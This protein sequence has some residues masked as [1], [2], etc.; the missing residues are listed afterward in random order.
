MKHTPS[1]IASVLCSA[2]FRRTQ[3]SQSA[4]EF[5]HRLEHPVIAWTWPGSIEALS[6]EAS[7]TDLPLADSPED[8]SAAL[9]GLLFPK[10]AGRDREWVAPMALLPS[11]GAAGLRGVDVCELDFSAHAHLYPA[12]D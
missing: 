3:A 8:L 7:S 9:L 1:H 4:Q 11:G 2:A 6:T 5:A 10:T 12:A